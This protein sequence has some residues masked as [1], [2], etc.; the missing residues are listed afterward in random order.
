VEQGSQA[1][2]PYWAL[3]EGWGGRPGR[4]EEMAVSRR[5]VLVLGGALA[6]LPV[7]AQLPRARQSKVRLGFLT[8]FMSLR[9]PAWAPFF[10]ELGDRGW[11]E[12]IEYSLEAR[13]YLGDYRRALALVKELISLPVDALIAVSGGAAHAARAV[14]TSVPVVAWLG[15]PVEAGV[16]QSLAR[17]GG[18]VTGVAN[19]ASPEVWGKVVELLREVAPGL[20]ELGVLWDYAPPGFPDGQV[21]LPI[22][23]QTAKRAG[24]ATQLWINRSPADVEVAL[25]AIERKSLGGVIVSAGG[26]VHAQMADRIAQTFAQRRLPA[27]SDVSTQSVFEKAGCVLAYSPNIPEVLAR[28]ASLTDRVLRGAKPAELPFELPS[29]FDLAVNARAA[30]AAGIR[31]PQSMLARADRVIE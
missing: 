30:K 9:T 16:A 8:S 10:K 3:G 2:A 21:P 29:R 31:I 12:G 17:P 23:E 6:A 25:A 7:R 22:I 28:L 19:Y 4:G 18:N 11:R 14:T 1:A 27:I 15:Y 20:R 26:G 24:I 5:R 13:E